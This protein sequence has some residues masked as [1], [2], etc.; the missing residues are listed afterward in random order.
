[1]SCKRT[2][3]NWESFITQNK[4]QD[5]DLYKQWGDQFKPASLVRLVMQQSTTTTLAL[6]TASW[7]NL[8][9]WNPK[10][11]NFSMACSRQVA[12]K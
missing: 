7:A 8:G 9:S 12:A 10:N 1:M 11:G 2:K 5:P 4:Q 3:F 6:Y